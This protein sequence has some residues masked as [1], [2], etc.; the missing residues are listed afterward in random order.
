MNPSSITRGLLTAALF[1]CA[2]TANA[3]ADDPDATELEPLVVEGERGEL[4]SIGGV[5]RNRLPCI[6]DCEE[7]EDQASA[8]QRLLRGIETLFIASSLPDKPEPHEA[9]TLVNPIAA[10]LDDK[11]P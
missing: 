10:R 11:L 1:G 4:D 8:L 5:Y 3:Q 7:S 9:R 2:V 6:G